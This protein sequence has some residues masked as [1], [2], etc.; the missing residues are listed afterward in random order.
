MKR[1]TTKINNPYK[2][3][4]IHYHDSLASNSDHIT[5]I[6]SDYAFVK[7]LGCIE[8]YEEE[9]GIECRTILLALEF[10]VSYVD[11]SGADCYFGGF[12]K[13]NDKIIVDYKNKCLTLI[14]EPQVYSGDNWFE[15]ANLYFKDYGK[16]WGCNCEL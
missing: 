14:R 11:G 6:Y 15:V 8:D 13:E 1:Y 3:Y 10:G 12:Q 16:T 2:P 5:V 9:L 7:K 4:R